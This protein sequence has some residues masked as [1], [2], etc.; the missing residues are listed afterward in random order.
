M[1]KRVLRGALADLL[2]P[3]VR[4]RRDKLGFVTPEARFMKRGLGSFARGVLDDPRTRARG[5]VNVDEALRRLDTG[6]VATFSVWRT[7]SVE[8][9]ARE[10]LD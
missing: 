7:V 4:D 8:L 6:A 9:W 2:P 3:A 5:F 1:T 10:F